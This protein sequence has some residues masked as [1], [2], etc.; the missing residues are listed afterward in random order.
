MERTTSS[1]IAR[2]NESAAN[3][4]DLYPRLTP[5][6]T[7]I[8]ELFAKSGN[9]CAFPGCRLPVVDELG[10][11]VAEVVH[12]KGVKPESPRFDATQT[13]EDRRHP[14]NLLIMCNP[15]HKVTNDEDI[16]PVARLQSIK[17]DHEGRFSGLIVGLQGT[18]EDKTKYAAAHPPSTMA[19]YMEVTGL[20]PDEA[21]SVR[22]QYLA[23]LDRLRSLPPDARSV[24]ATIIDRDT[25]VGSLA[26]WSAEFTFEVLWAELRDVLGLSND[27]LREQI[28]ILKAA[29]LADLDEEGSEQSIYQPVVVAYVSR[30]IESFVLSDLAAVAEAAQVPIARAIV[31]LDFR[32]LDGG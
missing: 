11:V 12:I 16:Y 18:V 24:L 7:T 15:H 26:S 32:L 21:D 25:G 27:L 22:E 8:K 4:A 23:L 31:G 6:E 5:R 9:Q 1:Y 2:V 14:S 30:G 13:P 19:R 20:T 10:T 28:S 3:I 17:V 29:G